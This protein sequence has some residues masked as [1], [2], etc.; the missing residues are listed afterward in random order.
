MKIKTKHLGFVVA[1]LALGGAA[2]TP[3]LVEAY[4]GDPSVQGPNYSV[5][6]HEVMTEAFANQDYQAWQ[7][8][9]QGRGRVTEVVTEENFDQFAEAHRLAQEGKLEEARQ[10]RQEL[11]LGL[12]NGEGRRG[13]R[14][15]Q[16]F[17]AD[18]CPNLQ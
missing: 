4:R 7:E 15:G 9:M 2:L 3:K 13:G 17:R 1:G 11:G 5:E 6:R 18:D 16:G 10:I 14:K 12:N 8:Q